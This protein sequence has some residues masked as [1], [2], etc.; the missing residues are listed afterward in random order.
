MPFLLT[1][2]P[3]PFL[4]ANHSVADKACCHVKIE[5]GKILTPRKISLA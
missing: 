3:A 1:S 2:L 5:N 4:D